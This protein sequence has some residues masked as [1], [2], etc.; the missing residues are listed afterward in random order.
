[1]LA[2]Q[3]YKLSEGLPKNESSGLLAQIRRA[4]VSI[5]SNIAEGHGRLTLLN[6][7]I[8]SLARANPAHGANGANT[9]S[10]ANTAH[11]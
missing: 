3:A 8:S 6:A 2:R 11:P 5:P 9:A 10:I 1:M 4:A 7:L